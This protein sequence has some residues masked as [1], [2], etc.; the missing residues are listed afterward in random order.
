MEDSLLTY[1][2]VHGC[3]VHLKQSFVFC[4]SLDIDVIENC[5]PLYLIPEMDIVQSQAIMGI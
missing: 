4:S 3:T 2:T 5:L 1:F